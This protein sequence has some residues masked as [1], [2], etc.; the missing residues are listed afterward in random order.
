MIMRTP[1]K[2]NFRA[3]LN[4][5]M[6]KIAGAKRVPRKVELLEVMIVS[7]LRGWRDRYR[8]LRSR[9]FSGT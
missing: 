4:R 2:M 8:A 1:I 5:S 9:A 6:R 3:Y 7:E